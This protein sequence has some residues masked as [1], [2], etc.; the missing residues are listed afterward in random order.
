MA[1]RTAEI[2][3]KT[4]ETDIRL[5]LAIDGSGVSEVETGV[6]FLDHMLDL[7]ARTR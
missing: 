7:F 3:R 4:R 1:D 2:V 5:G 6:G